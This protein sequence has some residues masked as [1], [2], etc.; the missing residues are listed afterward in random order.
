[1]VWSTTRLITIGL[2]TILLGIG[3]FAAWS[4]AT[5][6]NGAV[7]AMGQVEVE[8][9]R[10]TVQHPDGG[11]VA[12]I[13]IRD[14]DLVEAGAALIRL[15]GTELEARQLLL[16]RGLFETLAR[17]DRL[18][19]EVLDAEAPDYR[20]ELRDAAAADA[21]VA[22]VLAS[23]TALFASRRDTMA[24]TL[25]QLD[26]RKLQAR[27]QIEGFGR[28]ITAGET[29]LSLIEKELTDQQSLYE[30]GLTQFRQVSVLQREAAS[31][32]GQIGRLQASVAEINS[33]RA[34]YEIEALRL[35]AARREE[36]QNELRMLEPRE[37][38]LRENLRVVETALGRLIL[39]APMT[40][41]VLDLK[42]HT[43]GGV[44]APGSDIATIVPAD[45]PLI[46]V[47]RIDPRQ[48]DRLQPGQGALVRFPNFD[49]R[50]T[51]SFSGVLRSLSADT[52]LDAQSGV[53]FYTAE[54]T[55]AEE[56]RAALD[57]FGLQ[58]GMPLEAFIQT[59]ARTPAS[60]L[61]KPIADYMSYALREE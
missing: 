7:V 23:E 14:G 27:A 34:G 41:R 4:V 12:A 59:S 57:G 48:V 37:I 49:S 54:L 35:S 50:T 17:I 52:V 44:I 61:L 24:Q 60:F 56:S 43:I 51:P 25:A 6:I 55:I 38:E 29:Q 18:S 5:E 2:L 45:T 42:V 31:L 15:D 10:Q 33:A 13:E 3:G 20:A 53:A 21:E 32:E 11:L 22:R 28:E 30:R 8:A 26:E 19:A 46:F 47:L 1:M 40:G 9:R 39:R 58:P 16:R 36:A